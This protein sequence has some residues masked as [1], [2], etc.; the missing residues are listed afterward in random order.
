MLAKN[1]NK[2]SKRL[3]ISKRSNFYGM[4]KTAAVYKNARF[5]RLQ[6]SI[7]YSYTIYCV[8]PKTSCLDGKIQ[9]RGVLKNDCEIYW[10]K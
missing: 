7:N 10:G 4:L 1:L 8:C 3:L 9:F 6:N 5:S 2:K